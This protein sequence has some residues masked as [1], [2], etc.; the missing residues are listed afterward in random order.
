MIP[1]IKNKLKPR[2]HSIVICWDSQKHED[3]SDRT[4]LKNIDSE[5]VENLLV[6][7]DFVMEKRITAQMRRTLK[8]KC[9]AVFLRN[10]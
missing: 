6:E 10:S 9:C 7:H 4:V 2:Q 5:Y 1:L 3:S 8:S